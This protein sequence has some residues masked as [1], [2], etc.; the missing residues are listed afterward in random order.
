MTQV[1]SCNIRVVYSMLMRRQLLKHLF[2][3]YDKFNLLHLD[4]S[5]CY[6][7]WRGLGKGRGLLNPTSLEVSVV[8]NMAEKHIWYIWLVIKTSLYHT[9]I[10]MAIRLIRITAE[11]ICICFSLFAFVTYEITFLC[12][13][14]TFF[15]CN[16]GF[17]S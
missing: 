11:S 7:R 8:L 15:L 9:C 10:L 4:G 16:E 1:P 13:W 17:V 3:T 5:L 6:C 14:L 2:T 12:G